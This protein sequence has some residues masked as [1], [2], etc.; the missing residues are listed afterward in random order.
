MKRYL[1]RSALIKPIEA[2]V[3]MGVAVVLTALFNYFDAFDVLVDFMQAHE[4]WQLDEYFLVLAFGGIGALI[5]AIRRGHELA[6]EMLCRE[7]AERHALTLARHDPLTGLVN[8]RVLHEELPAL[9]DGA[10]ASGRQCA[11]FVIDLDHFKPVNDIH[12]HE[13]GDGVLVEVADRLGRAC[14]DGLTARLGGDEFV[15]V[16]VHEAGTDGPARM[17][18]QIVRVLGA[19]YQIG[20]RRLEL[21]ATVGIARAPI[22]STDAEELLRSADVAMYDAKR[23]GKGSY[24]FF[25]AEMDERLRARATLEADLRQAIEAGEIVPYF[26][27]VISLAEDRIVGFEALARWLHPTRGMIAPDTFIPVAEDLGLID[28]LSNRIL[29]QGCI[30]ARDWHPDTTLSFNISPIQLKDPWLTARL[31]GILAETGFS[32]RRL[33]VEVTENAI[34]EDIE[35]TAEVFGALQNSGIRVALD[36]FGKGYS[37]LSH[38]RQLKFNHLKIDSSF[39]QSMDSIESQQIVTA[40]AG[41]GKALGMPVTAEGVETEEAAATLRAL[42]CEQAQGY[43]FG[44]ATPATDA[45]HLLQAEDAQKARAAAGVSD[46]TQRVAG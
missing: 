1:G 46:I 32:P 12:G 7:A 17:A 9:I 3:I 38:L 43:L 20:E 14:P 16:L 15:A 19:P 45:A 5:L 29:R 2:A 40:V 4:A 8:R 26:Q 22:D 44:K 31:L 10:S 35:L 13:V 36:D 11:V 41:L 39:V 23:A 6:A 37:S 21:G 33:I 34:I 27:P 28:A 24:R 18:T 30:A 42:G 25:H